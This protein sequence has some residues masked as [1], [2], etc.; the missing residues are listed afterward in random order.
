MI[1]IRFL[2]DLK[3]IVD[4]VWEDVWKNSARTWDD[5]LMAYCCHLF[6]YS[7]SLSCL[8]LDERKKVHRPNSSSRKREP[9]NSSE[10]ILPV[11]FHSFP[12]ADWTPNARKPRS[13]NPMRAV[14]GRPQAIGY[15]KAAVVLSGA[16]ETTNWS[17]SRAALFLNKRWQGFISDVHTWSIHGCLWLFHASKSPWTE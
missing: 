5:C 13:G 12:K 7:F 1:F 9:A 14:A 6:F 2:T 11:V 4:D 8:F 3:M 17:T 16:D 10:R 15:E